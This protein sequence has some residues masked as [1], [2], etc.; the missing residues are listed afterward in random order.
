M[1][2]DPLLRAFDFVG[3][4]RRSLAASVGLGAGGAL[5]ALGLAALSAWLITRAWQM[6]PVLYLSVAVTAVRAL[7]IS[8]ALFRYLERLASHRVALDAMASARSRVYRALAGGSGVGARRSELLARTADDVDE[9]GDAVVRGVVPMAVGAVT[10][11]AAV[12]IMAVV[13]P[14]SAVV[15]AGALLISGVLAPWWAARASVA[16]ITDGAAARQR[17]GHAVTNALWH[18]PELVVARRRRVVLQRLRDAENDHAHA[19]DA[20]MARQ[21][22]AASMTPVAMLVSVVAAAVIAVDLASGLSGS[23]ASASSSDGVITPMLFGVLVLLP[24]SAFETTGPLTD[25]AIAWQRGRQAAARVMALVDDAG[26]VLDLDRRSDPVFS[27]A[28]QSVTVRG[29]QW[30]HDRP[31][32]PAGGIDL[33]LA[34]GARMLVVGRSG[35][36]KS[37]LAA[38][39]AGQLRP[40]AGSV[41]SEPAPL[42]CS[43]A[44]F[45]EEGHLFSTS[46]R[47]NLRVAR[48]DATD[49]DFA[50][51]LTAVGLGDWLAALPDGL[52]TDL[53]GGGSALSG[54]QRRRILLARAVLHPARVVVLDEPTEHVDSDDAP[55]LLRRILD[56]DGLFGSERTVI[57]VTHQNV[58][59]FNVLVVSVG[60]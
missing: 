58:E 46:L 1:R 28:P 48:G 26:S 9:I 6:P 45:A 25:A 39:I 38:T 44:Y 21:A 34:P 30:G 60:M 17:T 7:G 52:D 10:G 32:G 13:S 35:A 53:G 16:V 22:L 41:S 15:L 49:D 14:L 47:E 50:D 5:S 11:L 20:G 55:A 51:A 18:G 42:Q 24:L 36:G 8:R 12:V 27:A 2:S 43:V 3:L 29:L 54:G 19:V 4:R 37:T 23:L 56:A 40:L 31:L 59:E 57:V 33:D